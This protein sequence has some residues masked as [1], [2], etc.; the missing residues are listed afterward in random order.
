MKLIF[1]RERPTL[2]NDRGRFFQSSASIDSAF[3]SSHSV[4]A[5]SAASVIASEYPH[6]WT[7]ALVYTGAAGVSITRLMGQQ[8]FPS[9]VLVGSAAGW[10]VG[11]YVY[12]H[13]HRRDFLS[14]R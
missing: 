6:F 12:R 8:H 5:W 9:D 14:R 2:D 10:L 7:Q 11:R 3:P 1:W 4:L 13:H